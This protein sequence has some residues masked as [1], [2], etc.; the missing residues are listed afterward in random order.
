MHSSAVYR[1]FVTGASTNRQRV[2]KALTAVA[3]ATCFWFILMLDRSYETI[4]LCPLAI[5]HVPE[6]ILLVHTA[7]PE[8]RVR[9]EGRGIDL[10][11]KHLAFTRDTLVLDFDTSHVF[12]S[13]AVLLTNEAIAEM[14]RNM[15]GG[16]TPIRVQPEVIELEFEK[17]SQ[18]VYQGTLVQTTLELPLRAINVPPRTEVRFSHPRIS[19]SCNVPAGQVD[20][21]HGSYTEILV[22]YASL[23]T[24][25]AVVIPEVKLP[26]FVQIVSRE[27]LEVSYTIQQQ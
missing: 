15:T 16:V 24:S 11:R 18:P 10:L 9:V 6:D 5:Q 25:M 20:A 17:R 19:L 7:Q 1:F 4:L 13:N 27:P 21:V 3:A 26:P 22:D 12:G 23:D 2:V 8:A 14:R